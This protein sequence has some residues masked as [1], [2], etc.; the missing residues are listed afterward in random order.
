MRGA[1]RA[2]P[3]GSSRSLA[4]SSPR[5]APATPLPCAQAASLQGTTCLRVNSLQFQYFL[6]PELI[7]G[8]ADFLLVAT[9][10]QASP[11]LRRRGDGLSG[12]WPVLQNLLQQSLLLAPPLSGPWPRGSAGPLECR[13]GC[14]E[15]CHGLRACWA[16]PQGDTCPARMGGSNPKVQCLNPGR[17]EI[18]RQMLGALG[19][20]RLSLFAEMLWKDLEGQGR[21]RGTSV[22]GSCSPGTLCA[23][24]T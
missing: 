21:G 14:P 6:L 19:E 9:C 24:F 8:A 23:S 12:P 22:P 7:R 16:G 2:Q 13:G 20:M 11:F 10:V 17:P 1:G 15:K 3:A 18:H 4:L 5:A